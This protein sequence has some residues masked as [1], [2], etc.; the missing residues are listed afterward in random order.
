MGGLSAASQ[1]HPACTWPALN[2]TEASAAFVSTF[3][4]VDGS[5]LD[6]VGSCVVARHLQGTVYPTLGA[7]DADALRS[8][9]SAS[10]YRILMLASLALFANEKQAV[11]PWAQVRFNTATDSLILVPTSATTRQLFADVI[12]VV[13]VLVLTYTWLQ[14]VINDSE[15]D[16]ADGASKSEPP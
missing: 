14:R 12:V 3:P 4:T 11:E 6:G 13:S 1:V 15:Q 5:T 7:A 2:I 8:L 16:K 9:P 10:L